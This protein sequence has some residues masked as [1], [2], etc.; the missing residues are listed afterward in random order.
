M[1]MDRTTRTASQPQFTRTGGICW[2]LLAAARLKTG[3]AATAAAACTWRGRS[4]EAAKTDAAA[5]P[6]TRLTN[7]LEGRNEYEGLKADILAATR[8]AGCR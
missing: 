2:Y 1:Q 5:L 7:E 4:R 6:T 3:N 8:G